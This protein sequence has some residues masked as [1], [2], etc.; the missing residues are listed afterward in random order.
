VPAT[1][2]G[3][4]D[5]APSPGE[6]TR[7]SPEG[8]AGE[9]RDDLHTAPPHASPLLVRDDF[10]VW[11]ARDSSLYTRFQL[12]RFADFLGRE[13][14]GVGYR[15]S[16]T[17]LARARRQGITQEQISSFLTRSSGGRTPPRVVEGVRKWYGRSGSVQLEQSTLLRVDR[18]EVLKALQEH[19]EIGPLLGERLGPQAVLV[20]RRNVE[21]VRRWLLKHGYLE[22]G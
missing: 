19:A 17:S 4:R 5:V 9:F 12:A 15:I 21:Q 3:Q 2:Q 20:P 10:S 16:S 6:E 18:P 11:V 13:T 22:T 1:H 14:D 7:G 8:T